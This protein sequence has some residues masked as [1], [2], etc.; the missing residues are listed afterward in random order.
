[1]VGNFLFQLLK[2]FKNMFLRVDL[3]G[4][5]IDLYSPNISTIASL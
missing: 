2:N 5:Q 4:Q 1:M 3:A